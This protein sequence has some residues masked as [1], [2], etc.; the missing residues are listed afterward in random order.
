MRPPIKHYST[1]DS[2]NEE[3]KRRGT[4]GETGPL[5]IITDHQTHGRGRRSRHWQS[6]AGNL[7]ATGLYH[8]AG[9]LLRS[10]QLG[11]AAALAATDTLSSFVRDPDA[12]TIKWPNDILL[13]GAKIAGIL[14]E[15]G[16]SRHGGHWIAVGIGINLAKAPDDLPYPATAL[17]DHLKK[18]R[19]VPSPEAVLSKLIDAFERWRTELQHEGFAPLRTAWLS[20]AHGLGRPLSTSAG[21]T[22]VFEDL[23]KE[24]A[25]VLRQNTGRS[26]EISAGE[27]FFA[28]REG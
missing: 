19:E 6:P 14:L 8:W 27:V 9:P 11:F 23:S 20:R 24:G 2:T 12:L 15:S 3:A 13:N 18:G 16:A 10:A 1:L 21:E 17:G 26:I 5:W 7:A 22:G 25:L 28:D 4:A